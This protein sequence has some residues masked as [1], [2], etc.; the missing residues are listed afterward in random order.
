[1][2]VAIIINPISGG[3]RP[4]V[5]RARAELARS[6]VDTHGDLAEVFVTERAGH[7]R[8]L[9][10]AAIARGARL[11]MAWGGDG[12]INE[13][14]SALAFGDVPLGIVPA[15][16]GNGLARELGIDPHPQRAIADALRAEPRP[17]DAGQ[18]EDRLFVNLAGV[19]F[20]AYVAARFN[21]PGNRRRGLLGY[22]A[23]SLR[24]V[25]A[26]ESTRYRISA[27]AGAM[28]ESR[29][30]L[31]TIANSAQF[32]NGARIAP[33]ARVD[34]G[35]LDLVVVEERSRLATLVQLPRLFDGNMARVPGCSIRQV[36][37][38]VI[39]ADLPMTFH[40][41][42]EPVSGGTRLRARVRPGA[43]R[44]CVKPATRA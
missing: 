26:Y 35:Q 6:I 28:T 36:R 37:E 14:A 3:A 42:G 34:D 22:A 19:G 39:E 11:V 10:K 20:D 30:V 18:I 8:E 7:A 4:D 29:A 41:D 38:V 9:A 24:A 15:G 25:A 21:A 17:L 16:S 32:G 43:L 31:V 27:D 12:T 13:V 23:I 44:V 40:V 2:P 1:M 5:A 33:G